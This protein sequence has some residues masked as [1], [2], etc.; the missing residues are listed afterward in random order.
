MSKCLLV[1]ACLLKFCL[2]IGDFDLVKSLVSTGADF[3]AAGSAFHSTPLHEA[4]KGKYINIVKVLISNGADVNARGGSYRF[5]TA[6]HQASERGFMNIA[7]LLIIAGADVN[8]N[9]SLD[10]KPLQYAAYADNKDIVELLLQ[11]GATIA[12]LHIG[13]DWIGR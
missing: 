4:V 10:S 6:L 9:D 2:G 1:I 3:N 11:K 7:R 13:H 5:E 12:N 8:A